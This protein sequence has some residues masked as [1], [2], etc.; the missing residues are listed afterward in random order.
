MSERPIIFSGPMVRAILAG[1]KTQTRRVIKPPLKH[2]GWTG[3][4]YYPGSA[5]AIENGPDYP[6]TKSDERRCPYGKAGDT[7]WVR[8]T[9]G[10]RGQ[11]YDIDAPAAGP[12][13]FR[14][15]GD[16]PYM[17]GDVW[18]PSIHLRRRDARL[19][20]RVT[21]VRVE[22]LQDISEADAEAEGVEPRVGVGL[23]ARYR[24][25]YGVLWDSINAKRSNHQARWDASWSSNPWV[26]VITFEVLPRG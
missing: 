22:R 11:F 10:Y 12:L 19:L 5:I 6:D 7:L 9:W 17:H 4:S 20:L 23:I 16:P 2:P 24:Q 3:F 14:A 1:T 13:V 8:E 21:A 25:S 18:R 26:W 15:D